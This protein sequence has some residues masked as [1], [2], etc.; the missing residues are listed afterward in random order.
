[1]VIELVVTVYLEVV[2]NIKNLSGQE[3]RIIGIKRNRAI[4]LTF[5]GIKPRIVQG[6]IW[7]LLDP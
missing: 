4:F 1:V 3:E 6:L 5:R 2:I 7:K